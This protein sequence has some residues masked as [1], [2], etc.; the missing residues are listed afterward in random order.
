[1]L[2]S[3]DC[4]VIKC[5]NHS[6]IRFQRVLIVGFGGQDPNLTKLK[7]TLKLY[8]TVPHFL[9]QAPLNGLDW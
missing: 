2:Y 4:T 1:M 5:L 7:S 3:V 9:P 8:M 6:Q